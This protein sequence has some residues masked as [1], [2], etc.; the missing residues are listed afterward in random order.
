MFNNLLA[1]SI[2][3]EGIGVGMT[4]VYA[5]IGLVVVFIGIA[6]LIYVVWAVGRILAKL[7]GE[8]PVKKEKEASVKQSATG[9]VSAANTSE[10]VPEEV[11]AAITAA[12]MAYYQTAKPQCGFTVKRIKKI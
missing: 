6:F 10:E 2:E 4:S 12:L 7:N 9:S 1:T 8:I 5:L 11:V 3:H